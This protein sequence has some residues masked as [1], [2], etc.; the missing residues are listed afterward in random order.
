MDRSLL[1]KQFDKLSPYTDRMIERG[2]ETHR[3]G[4]YHV[5]RN[6]HGEFGCR[7]LPICDEPGH[8][9]WCFDTAKKYFPYSR[10]FWN[11]G[12][13]ETF[14]AAGASRYCG[15][16]SVYY[17]MLKRWLGEGAPIE[18]IGMQFHDFTGNETDEYAIYNPY[19]AMDIFDLYGTFGLP[20]HLSE[21]SIP[22]YSNEPEDEAIQQM[23]K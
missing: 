6:A 21:V 20:I 23:D 4:M 22:S 5:Y 15:D 3:K 1:V 9:K 11:E 16:K 18:G 7:D 10:L 13:F 2:I 12:C 17:L 8:E 14:G 19:R